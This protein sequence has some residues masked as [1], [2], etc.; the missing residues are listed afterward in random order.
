MSPKW[1]LVAMCLVFSAAAHAR[2]FIKTENVFV[3][4]GF[5]DNDEVQVIA[6]GYLENPCQKISESTVKKD[7]HAKRIVVEVKAIMETVFCNWDFRVPFT[8]VL[9]LGQM[10]EGDYTVMTEDGKIV[11]KLSVARAKSSS[12]DDKLY[13]PVDRVRVKLNQNGEFEAIIEGRFPDDCSTIGEL[14][15]TNSGKTLEILP[16]MVREKKHPG[17]CEPRQVPFEATKILPS[18]KPGK[19]LVHVRSLNGQSENAVFSTDWLKL[20]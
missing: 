9:S 1:M 8:R 15:L 14:E 4:N 20:P 5:D 2:G 18:L 19:Y 6:D 7:L 3:P 11:E 12:P 16:L 13:A 17:Q 10:P